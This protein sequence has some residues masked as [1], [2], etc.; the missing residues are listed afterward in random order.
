MAF[1]EESDNEPHVSSTAHPAC[2]CGF[3]GRSDM[4]STDF[5]LD[6]SESA[7]QPEELE[8]ARTLYSGILLDESPGITP[9]NDYEGDV[10]LVAGSSNLG[11]GAGRDRRPCPKSSSWAGAGSGRSS[12]LR[13][14]QASCSAG[15]GP[16]YMEHTMGTS[17][18]HTN[19]EFQHCNDTSSYIKQYRRHHTAGHV[20]GDRHLVLGHDIPDPYIAK[21]KYYG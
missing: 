10:K 6:L 18:T 3:A 4:R 5:L 11:C 20:G 2:G 19:F 14:W 12:S 16:G 15:R 13:S 1:S 17:H 21:L 9:W 8:V 7:S